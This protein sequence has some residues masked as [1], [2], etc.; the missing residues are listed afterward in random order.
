MR[1]NFAQLHSPTK[2]GTERKSSN[3]TTVELSRSLFLCMYDCCMRQNFN[4]SFRASTHDG[5]LSDNN[6]KGIRAKKEEIKANASS[7]IITDLLKSDCLGC[8]WHWVIQIESKSVLCVSFC[9]CL[10]YAT[11]YIEFSLSRSINTL[12]YIMYVK[13]I[14][15]LFNVFTLHL[16]AYSG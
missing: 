12:Q 7:T 6:S 11:Q 2:M 13:Y 3:G 8:D 10:C 1:T 5:V 14:P 4:L 16:F 9:V 15:S